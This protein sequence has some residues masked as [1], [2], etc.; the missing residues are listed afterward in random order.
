MDYTVQIIDTIGFWDTQV[1][2]TDNEICE[3]IMEELIG[4]GGNL[5][6]I[7]LDM[8]E[9]T[10][11][12]FHAPDKIDAILLVERSTGNASCVNQTFEKVGKI[13]GGIEAKDSMILMITD[14]KKADEETV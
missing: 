13:F 8:N 3:M 1:K 11:R 14:F 2:Y 4:G 12:P 6:V 5:E 10:V 7:N 9:G